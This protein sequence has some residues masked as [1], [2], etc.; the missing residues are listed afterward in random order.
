MLYDLRK[1]RWGVL[2]ELKNI[3][4]PTWSRDSS[5]IYFHTI[6]EQNPA[7]YRVRRAD[8]KLEELVSL[9][10][11]RRTTVITSTMSLAPDDSPVLLQNTGIEEIYVLN[12]TAQ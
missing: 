4:Q 11:F 3:L 6:D 9:K 7:I 1:E 8:G 5:Y 12:T 2:A 10:G